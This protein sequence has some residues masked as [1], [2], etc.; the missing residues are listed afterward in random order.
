MG[1]REEYRDDWDGKGNFF[2]IGLLCPVQYSTMIRWQGDL[3]H[4]RTTGSRT[5]PLDAAK[6]TERAAW[7]LPEA[8][9]VFGIIAQQTWSTM[10]PQR[11]ARHVAN[12][13]S[14]ATGTGQAVVNASGCGGCVE[15]MQQ[16]KR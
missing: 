13:A 2:A 9:S 10:A 5:Q 15:V 16:R 3:T 14:N 12:D 11:A 8:T 4:F 6:Q 7:Q 1:Y